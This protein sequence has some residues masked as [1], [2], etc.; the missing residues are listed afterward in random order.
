MP[1]LVSQDAAV[2]TLTLNRPDSLNALDVALKESLLSH[3][4]AVAA[5][6]EVRAVVLAGAGRA[7]CVGQDLREHAASL[8]STAAPAPSPSPPLPP[9][10][11]AYAPAPDKALDTVRVHYAPIV[12]ALAGMPKPVV[13]AVRG[14]AAG[15]GAGLAFLADFRVGGP[16]TAFLTAFANIGLAADTGISWTLPR[17]VGHGKATEL[18]MLSEPVRAAEADALG[19]LTQLVDSDESVLSAAQQLA[20]RLAA[21]PTVAYAQLKRELAGPGLAAALEVEADAQAVCGAT[22]DHR[23]ATAAF[24]AKQKPTFGGS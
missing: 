9:A 23:N 15:A 16:S 12:Q 19:L 17:L 22:A 2:A 14:M 6:P 11:R 8:E 7:F 20:A 18:L 1:L 21:G 13:A 24:V 4:G 3:L 10:S 5:D